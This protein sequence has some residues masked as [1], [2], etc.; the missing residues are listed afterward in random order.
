M[1]ILFVLTL[2]DFMFVKFCMV[3][4]HGHLFHQSSSCRSGAAALLA[5]DTQSYCLDGWKRDLIT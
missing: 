4:D 3:Y 5:G 2:F 1:F